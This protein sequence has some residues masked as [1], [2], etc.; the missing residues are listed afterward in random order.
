MK[1]ILS[2]SLA[3]LLLTSGM[4]LT[5]ASHFCGDMLAQVKW[6]M[7]RELASCGMENGVETHPKG[8]ALHE[9]CCKDVV[10]TYA[11]DGQYQFQSLELKAFSPQVISSFTAPLSMLFKSQDPADFHYTHV[12][13]PG[14]VL[15]TQVLQEN[16]CVFLI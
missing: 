3:L 11:T 15:P 5:I 12:F 4:H 1:R 2:I 9:A 7:D 13:P 10:S 6:S 8:I 16:I 14:K